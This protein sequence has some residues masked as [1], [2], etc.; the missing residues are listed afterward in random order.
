MMYSTAWTRLVFSPATLHPVI[1]TMLVS[2]R[3]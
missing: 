2:L 1:I 3:H